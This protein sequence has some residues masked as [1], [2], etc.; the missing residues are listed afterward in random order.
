MIVYCAGHPWTLTWADLEA[1]NEHGRT[2]VDSQQVLIDH[3]L[4]G[5]LPLLQDTLVHELRHVEDWYCGV[6][7]AERETAVHAT[8]GAQLLAPFLDLSPLLGEQCGCGKHGP[9]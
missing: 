1:H 4:R 3:G 9:A 6:E 2:V 8:L 7:P 5:N